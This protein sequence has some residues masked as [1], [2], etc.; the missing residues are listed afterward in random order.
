MRYCVPALWHRLRT[1]T[2]ASRCRVPNRNGISKFRGTIRN[3][4]IG[5]AV[6]GGE[7]GVVHMNRAFALSEGNSIAGVTVG[8]VGVNDRV[9][10]TDPSRRLTQSPRPSAAFPLLLNDPPPTHLQISLPQSQSIR[11]SASNCHSSSSQSL[12]YLFPTLQL[13]QQSQ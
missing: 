4:T 13:L 7:W 5:R 11:F 9:V 3:W 12:L 6:S 2:L 10:H 8:G 1:A